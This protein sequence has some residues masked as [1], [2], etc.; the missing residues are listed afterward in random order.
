MTKH[1]VGYLLA[2][3]I[4]SVLAIETPSYVWGSVCAVGGWV[5]LIIGMKQLEEWMG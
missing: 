4:L 1:I 5:L 2:F 3:V